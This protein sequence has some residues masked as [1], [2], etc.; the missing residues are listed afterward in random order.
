MTRPR[1]A[2]PPFIPPGA[3]PEEARNT[4]GLSPEVT[5]GVRRVVG[6]APVIMGTT[7][8][9]ISAESTL[10]VQ[11]ISVGTAGDDP[12][13]ETML[14]GVVINLTADVGSAN[15]A[16]TDFVLNDSDGTIYP[17]ASS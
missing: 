17:A 16:Y 6:A 11:P 2:L 15:Y 1:A 5:V 8:I 4:I 7:L 14:V 10:R 3:A 13:G 9:S 12:T